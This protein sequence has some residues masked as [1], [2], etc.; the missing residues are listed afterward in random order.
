MV[1]TEAEPGTRP[2]MPGRSIGAGVLLGVGVAAFLDETVFHQILHWHH[3][4]DRSTSDVGLVSDGFFH[5]GGWLAIVVG[6]FWFADLQRRRATV[7]RRVWA[8]GLIGWGAFQVYDGLF[9]HK[10][11]GLHQ[12]RYGVDLLPYDLAWDLSGAL[13]VVVGVALL[14]GPARSVA[15]RRGSR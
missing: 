2:A 14:F 11:L 1:S 4:Y 7:P 9:Q 6:L 15:E 12:I 13:G 5:A 10:A 8:G 3:F